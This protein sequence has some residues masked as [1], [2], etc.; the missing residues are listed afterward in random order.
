MWSRGV[1]FSVLGSVVILLV[2]LPPASSAPGHCI[3]DYYNCKYGD[4]NKEV[5]RTRTGLSRCGS[6]DS[7]H[8]SAQCATLWTQ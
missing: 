2:L 5:N 8:S 4:N 3:H 7:I 6:S 1:T